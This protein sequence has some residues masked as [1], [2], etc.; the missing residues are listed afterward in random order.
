MTSARDFREL[1][2][3]KNILTC[4]AHT[5]VTRLMWTKSTEP[6]RFGVGLRWRT[7]AR[8]A[9]AA[10]IW[11]TRTHGEVRWRLTRRGHVGT[12]RQ[13]R[14]RLGNRRHGERRR[15]TDGGW[16]GRVAGVI[17]ILVGCSPVR[18]DDGG[19]RRRARSGGA[20]RLLSDGWYGGAPAT[21]TAPGGRGGDGE[22]GGM[23]HDDAAAT[24]AAQFDGDEARPN[25]EN[26]EMRRR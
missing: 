3:L 7:R 2:E 25:G 16:Y 18:E 21:A 17:A 26:G 6:L 19:G 9:D 5:S 15:L 4:G 11:L 14:R 23:L 20:A 1:K 22:L 12:G 13:R 24:A 10:A 8:G